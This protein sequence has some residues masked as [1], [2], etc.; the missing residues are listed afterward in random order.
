MLSADLQGAPMDRIPICDDTVPMTCTISGAEV[1]ARIQL[2]ERMREGLDRIERTDHGLL[3]HFPASP[4]VEADLVT[5]TVD[6][7][8]CC[9]F[10]GF[11]IDRA[12]A[13]L[14]LRWDG[15]PDAQD[16]L[17]Q[18]LAYFQGDEELTAVSGLL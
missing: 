11:A 10:W 13:E 7:K 12:E 16:L 14:A 15:P 17:D 2:V 1:P 4:D 18:L 9:Q 3:L 8:R 5:F 6:E